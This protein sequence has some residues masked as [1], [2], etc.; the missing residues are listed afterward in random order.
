[1]TIGSTLCA[2]S[3]LLLPAVRFPSPSLLQL[4]RSVS[5][6]PLVAK[7]PVSAKCR[8]SAFQPYR[9]TALRAQPAVPAPGADDA[10]LSRSSWD[11]RQALLAAPAAAA[12]VESV[13][14]DARHK[15]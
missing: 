11:A 12:P 1:M 13:G 5:P 15:F 7:Y 10:I 3:A 8:S 4:T 6:S 14:G 2:A 9:P